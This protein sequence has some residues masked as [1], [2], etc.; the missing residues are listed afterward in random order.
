[1]A[2]SWHAHPDRVVSVL[3][4]MLTYAS[5]WAHARDSVTD[6]SLKIALL[7]FPV[8]SGLKAQS[9]LLQQNGHFPL[10]IVL[11]GCEAPGGQTSARETNSEFRSD[12]LCLKSKN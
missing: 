1:M 6:C 10:Q 7:A 5:E 3:G 2:H 11:Y 8:K 9:Q 4:R 12:F